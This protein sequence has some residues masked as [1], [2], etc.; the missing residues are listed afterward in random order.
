MAAFMNVPTSMRRELRHTAFA[1]ALPLARALLPTDFLLTPSWTL[2][3]TV[4]SIQ[5]ACLITALLSPKQG[6][7]APKIADEIPKLILLKAA[8]P[9]ILEVALNVAKSPIVQCG[10]G[11]MNSV[12]LA[13]TAVTVGLLEHPL[14]VVA[15]ALLVGAGLKG[16]LGL[17]LMSL[18]GPKKA[19]H[20][21]STTSGTRASLGAP[22]SCEHCRQS[23][24]APLASN[25]FRLQD[26]NAGCPYNADFWADVLP[27]RH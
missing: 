27:R 10:L 11:A 4:C 3:I 15:F 24:S 25:A 17:A 18:A 23:A 21:T 26:G 16:L 13:R 2:I 1:S 6:S 19:S 20:G 7:G 22:C 9:T 12:P 5:L 14:E 8:P